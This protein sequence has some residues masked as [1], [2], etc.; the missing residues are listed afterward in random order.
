MTDSGTCWR[1]MAWMWLAGGLPWL[2]AAET[3]FAARYERILQQCQ[4][5]VQTQPTNAEAAWKL[6]RA[7]FDC[8]E[9]ATNNARRAEMARQGIA[10]ALDA[11]RLKPDAA[12]AHYYHALNVGTLADAS[13]GLS[14][15]KLVSEMEHSFLKAHELDAAFDFAGADR[16]LGLL[17]R[18]AP[19]WPISV[20]SR[21]KARLHFEKACE[22]AGDYPENRLNQMD[23][24]IK[25]GDKAKAVAE[26][27]KVARVLA[28]AR[29]KLAGEE[30]ASAWADW[31]RQWQGIQVRLADAP[32]GFPGHKSAR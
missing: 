32:G 21:S 14:G 9:F 30:W 1:W 24:W 25:W 17:Y 15:L 6:A 5:V 19:G 2:A 18:D 13:R 27:K 12:P 23:A 26:T 16:S 28:E 29:K 20:G 31:D 4:T 7:W 8:A 10:A 11:I 3:N 22:L